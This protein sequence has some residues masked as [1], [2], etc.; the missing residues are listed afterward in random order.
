M[1]KINFPLWAIALSSTV[2]V[3]G[4]YNAAGK[5]G[6]DH[7]FSF[8][9]TA[10]V[11]D[12][13]PITFYATGNG[14]HEDGDNTDD[15]IFSASSTIQAVQPIGVEKHHENAVQLAWNAAVSRVS[16]VSAESHNVNWE[17]LDLNG[18]IV[19]T[20]C[21]Q[22]F[23]DFGE[24]ARGFYLVRCRVNGEYSEIKVVN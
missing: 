9:W 14:A 3:C 8:Q 21:N 11:Q 2:F 4:V 10:P 12:V 5:A 1:T 18:R 6:D 7:T 19:K 16:V 13:G 23:I 24:L 22:A 17:V 20:Q 15:F